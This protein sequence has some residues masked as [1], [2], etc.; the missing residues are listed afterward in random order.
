M[1]LDYCYKHNIVGLRTDTPFSYKFLDI[2]E[3]LRISLYNSI[4]IEDVENM[5]KVMKS[6]QN[7]FFK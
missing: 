2:N 4:T 5:V 7:L 1:F 6:F 3:P